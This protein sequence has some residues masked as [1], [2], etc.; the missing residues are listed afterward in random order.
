[1]RR[2]TSRAFVATAALGA[3][4][5]ALGLTVAGSAGAAAIWPTA[6]ATHRLVAVSGAPPV[7]TPLCTKSVGFTSIDPSSLIYTGGCAGYVSSGRDF[8]YAQAL[9]TLPPSGIVTVGSNPIPT[10]DIGLTSSDAAAVAGLTTCAGYLSLFGTDPCGQNGITD[11]VAFGVFL[12]NNGSGMTTEDFPVGPSAT[13]GTGV[14]F[15]IY[16]Y[17]PG[18]SLHFTITFGSTSTS[19]ATHAFAI[20]A[21]GAVFNRASALVDFSACASSAPTSVRAQA[22]INC[23]QVPGPAPDADLRLTQFFRG[24]FTTANGQK[25]TFAGPWT[26]NPA[27]VTSF[28][29][30]P[31]GNQ[32]QVEPAFLWN[33]GIGNGSGDAFGVWWRHNA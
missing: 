25:G 33:D 3:T 28:G 8:R 14:L 11:W 16:H 15:S 6:E 9:I 18:N 5:T 7:Y 2:R 24:A 19:P 17:Q 10:L 26:L 12:W 32:L 21:R 22:P 13:P 1:M 27:I 20:D 30:P 23:D 29:D 31:P 4:I